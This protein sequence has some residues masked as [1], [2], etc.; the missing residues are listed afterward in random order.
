MS[1]RSAAVS[2]ISGSDL[3]AVLRAEQLLP[4]VADASA[5]AEVVAASPNATAVGGTLFR[6]PGQPQAPS[7]VREGQ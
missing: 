7:K 1:T 3:R 4:V 6:Q 2:A 5:P